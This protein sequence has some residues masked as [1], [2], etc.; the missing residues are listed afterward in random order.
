MNSSV[1]AMTLVAAAL[2]AAAGMARAQD[3]GTLGASGNP[4]GAATFRA[5]DAARQ[6][7]AG[8]PRFQSTGVAVP[9]PALTK[10][11]RLGP[12]DLIEVEIFE[13]ENLKRTVRVNAAGMISLPL[14]GSVPVAGLSP[15]EVETLIAARYS[16]KYLQ[17]PQVSI[18][19]KEFTSERI[20]V[21]GA[22]TRPGMFP[23]T[24]QMTLLRA[25]ALAG[26][27]GPIANSTEVMI[28]R[29]NEKNVRQMAVFDIERIRA[30]QNEDPPIKGD[31]LIVV[32]RDKT[33]ALF[34]DSVF[35]DIMD[36]FNP[37][38]IFAR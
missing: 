24:G 22:V 5:V 21:E 20:T 8:A 38:T 29:V 1:R 28:F 13:M 25:L 27:F 11:Y 9:A 12:N 18:F 2:L 32:Q 7:D 15:P 34:K 19:I 36:S 33:R 37:F 4:D 16:E 10:D 23:L 26:G 14:I 30:G 6:G 17:N 35:R 31:D 3:T